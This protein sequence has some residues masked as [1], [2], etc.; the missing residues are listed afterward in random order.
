MTEIND[1]IAHPNVPDTLDRIADDVSRDGGWCQD[2]LGAYDQLDGPVC[3]FG[4]LMRYNVAF[5]T[6]ARYALEKTLMDT[7]VT[8]D[9]ANNIAVWNNHPDRTAGEVADAFRMTAKRL[10]EAESAEVTL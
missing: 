2:D 8:I 10:R 9:P 5:E 3:A 4:A 1:S 6:N 7:G